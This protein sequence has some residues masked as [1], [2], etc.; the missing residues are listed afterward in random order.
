V[1]TETPQGLVIPPDLL[2]PELLGEYPQARAVLDRYGLR[3]CGGRLGPFESIRF[4][5][6]AH[7]VDEARL[8]AEL[9]QAVTEAS[10][11]VAH[12][13]SPAAAI[14]DTIYRR[15][16]IGG[17]LLTLTAGAT[18]GAWMLWTIAL[19]GSFRGIS[20]QSV[21]AHGE[22]QIFGWVG[23]FIMG[24]A[25][26]A[27][28][29][30]WQTTLAAPRVAACVFAVMVAGLFARTIGT[31]AAEGWTFALPLAMAGGALEVAAVLVF[32]S[33]VLATFARSGARFE[34]YV[35]FIMAALG[36]FVVSSVLGVWHTWNT[37]TASGVEA[38]V[39]YIATYQAP[40]RD[41]Q[42]HG[43]AMFMIFGVALRMFP[44]LFDLPRVSDRR[45]WWALGLLIAAVS[46]EVVLFLV[47]RLTNNHI[48]AIYLLLPRALLAL[49]A[50]MVVWSWR[51][52]RPFP[53]SDRSGKFVRA[54]LAW[55]CVSLMMLML[56]PVY[57]AISG[58]PF[59][60][61]YYGAIRHAITVGF[62]SLLIMG[63][64]AKV[65]PTLNGIDPRTLSRLWGP[66]LLV[67]TGC[68]LRVVLQTLTDWSE[69]VY[70]L[71]GLSGTLEVAGLGWWGLGLVLLIQREKCA[72]GTLPP[73][74][75][76]QPERVEGT[77]LVG[78]LLDW[79]PEAESILVRHGFL[80]LR[81]PHFRRTL[82]R[83]VTV[84][85]AASLRG[86][87]VEPLL[88]ALNAAVARGCNHKTNEYLDNQ[89]LVQIGGTK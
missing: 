41:M 54:A 3:G 78:D 57:R 13:A 82:A 29:R 86:I 55:L 69:Q 65:V 25:Y 6:R 85:Q 28:P 17:I 44:A 15:F 60:H 68:F 37:L 48:F 7:G 70:P 35:G 88:E 79:F 81:Q 19:R 89:Q 53:V 73:R 27:F 36:W 51:P 58:L 64:A 12:H 32:S 74:A 63:M 47:Y 42:V 1:E 49:G 66:F 5:A 45:A 59:S 16:F 40:L 87:A 31:W 61:A 18:W 67:N 77:H 71:L 26:Q 72:A 46:G 76:G 39:W 80:L 8:V 24:F 75:G 22:A 20:V 84:T 4:F 83:H 34:P 30:I 52:W 50:V 14:A 9:E 11:P 33:Q 62:V 56:L 21:N 38:L 2:L 23:L 43:L 10:V